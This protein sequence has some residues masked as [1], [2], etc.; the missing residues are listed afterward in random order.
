M[1]RPLAPAKPLDKGTC[2]SAAAG[3]RAYYSTCSQH[4]ARHDQT[5]R[6][7]RS[8]GRGKQW[9]ALFGGP[10]TSYVLA[11]GG[12]GP[13]AAAVVVWLVTVVRSDGCRRISAWEGARTTSRSG[14]RRPTLCTSQARRSRPSGVA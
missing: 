5:Q 4:D 11:D 2:L 6:A 9:L 7:P 1:L 8:A 10:A 13:G 3:D 12:A 14:S